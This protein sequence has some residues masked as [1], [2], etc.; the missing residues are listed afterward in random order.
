MNNPSSREVIVTFYFE[1]IENLSGRS[2]NTFSPIYIN[3]EI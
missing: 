3:G 1:N 2:I